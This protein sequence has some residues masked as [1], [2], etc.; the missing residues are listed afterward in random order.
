[1]AATIDPLI[2]F[3]PSEVFRS[4]LEFLADVE[5][6]IPENVTKFQDGGDAMLTVDDIKWIY[7]RKERLKDPKS[8]VK[9]LHFHEL[10]EQ[11]Q[12]ILPEPKFPP[13]NP[14]LEARIQKLKAQQADREYKKMTQNI[15][16]RQGLGHEDQDEPI[17]KQIQELNNYLIIIL[18]FVISIICSFAFGYMVPYYFKG[19]VNTGTRILCGIICAFVVAIA[20]LYFVVKFLLESEGLIKPNNIK[21][22]DAQFPKKAKLKSS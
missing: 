8:P 2:R 21:V 7:D 22:Y 19:V 17:G 12:M 1:M 11:C 18:Q 4:F 9:D 3:R 15:D 13:R 10:V 16:G 20:D 6:G 5:S 14:E